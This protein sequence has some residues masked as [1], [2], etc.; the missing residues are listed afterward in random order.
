MLLEISV[1]GKSAHVEFI[2]NLSERIKLIVT[3]DQSHDIWIREL[4]TL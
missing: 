4:N 2:A 3:L 1:V